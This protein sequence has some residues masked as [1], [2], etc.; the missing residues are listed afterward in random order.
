MR[1][2]SVAMHKAGFSK[3]PFKSIDASPKNA[4]TPHASFRTPQNFSSLILK[5]PL[6]PILAL[7]FHT[8]HTSLQHRSLLECAS[9]GACDTSP[10]AAGQ[11]SGSRWRQNTTELSSVDG[12]VIQRISATPNRHN[13]HMR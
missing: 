13:S 9:G 10:P 11:P 5:N 6:T 7:P 4:T 1:R 3:T 12:S 8:V 2:R